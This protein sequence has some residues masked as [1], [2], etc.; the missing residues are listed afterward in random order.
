MIVLALI[1]VTIEAEA[2]TLKLL[3]RFCIQDLINY[4]I[5]EK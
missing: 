5:E 4:F 3:V 2:R 1:A